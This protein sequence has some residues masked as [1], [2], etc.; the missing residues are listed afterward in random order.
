MFPVFGDDGNDFTEGY[1]LSGEI[2]VFRIYD[3][4]NNTYT[5]AN[6][7]EN[8]PWQYLTNPIINQLSSTYDI[9]GCTWILML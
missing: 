2:P 3:I 6:P 8:I 5:D 7:S 1:L 9:L 4:S